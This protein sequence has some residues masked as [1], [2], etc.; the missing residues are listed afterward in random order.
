MAQP[1][2][3]TAFSGGEW[4][5]DL[6]SRVDLAKYHSAAQ[7]LKNFVVDYR[8]GAA[9]RPGTRYILQARDSTNQVRLIPFQASFTVSY[10]LEFG[11][12]YIRFFS[13][14]TAV[15]ETAIVI[16]GV[17]NAN[18]AV[19]TAPG[20]NYVVN[21][22]VFVNNV[23]G[24]SQLNGNYYI[25]IAVTANTF[26]I[27]GLNGTPVDS[28]AFGV[29]AGGGTTA[30]VYTIT[31][32]YSG[33]ELALVKFAQNVQSMV[34]CHPNHSAQLLTL[35]AANNW[36]LTTIAYGATVLPPTA[37]AVT[38]T[39]VGTGVNYS[40]TVTSVDSGGQE[41][42]KSIPGFLDNKADIRITPGTTT[43]NW[44]AADGAVS[45]NIYRAELNYGGVIPAG[46]AYGFLGNAT[47]LTFIDSNIA[48]DFSESPPISQD[49]FQGSSVLSLILE[50]NGAYT[51]V[52]LVTIDP[53]ASGEQ[54]TAFCSLTAVNIAQLN[55][56]PSNFD[57]ALNLGGGTPTGFNLT[58][59]NGVVCNIVSSSIAANTS[60]AQLYRINQLQVIAG[61]SV[62]SGPVPT[63]MAATGYSGPNL[64][65][66]NS[67]FT[68]DF[69]WVV[70]TNG[71]VLVSGG[72]GYLTAPGV[73]IN[74]GPATA[75]ATIQ[76]P[77]SGGGAPPSGIAGGNPEVPGFFQERLVLASQPNAL[78]TFYMSVPGAP[79]NFNIS[80]PVQ[81]SDSIT[82]QITSG[83]LNQIKS[84]APVPAG[85]IMFTNRASWLIN[86]GGGGANA[87]GV[88]V[89]P[90]NISANAQ[91]FNGASDVPP[92]IS[93]FDILYVQ[94]KGAVVRDLTFNFYAAIYTGTDVTVMAS[95]LFYGFTLDEWAWAEEPFKIVWAIRSDGTLLSLTFMKEQEMQGW[96]HSDTQGL[97]RSIC[98]VTEQV[99]FGAVDAIYTVVQRAVGGQWLQYI[100][101]MVERIFP[102]GME[103]AWCVDAALQT[104]P[105]NAGN[106]AG[107]PS[108]NVTAT[109]SAAFGPSNV[110]FS[111]N[112]GLAANV[113]GTTLRLGG[114]IGQIT[115]VASGS[116]CTVNFTTA[117][118]QVIPYT[119][120]PVPQTFDWSIWFPT[121]KVLGLQH[122]A[123]LQVSGVAD[124]AVVG[125]L[126]VQPDGSVNLPAPATKITLGLL[127]QPQLQTLRLDLGEPTA[128]GKRKSIIG[129]TLRVKDTLGL[130]S[131]K[132]LQTLTV[133]KD[134][135]LGQ[136]NIQDNRPVT[137]LYTG[138][139]R[140]I[141]DPQWDTFGTYYIVQPNPL[142]VTILGLMPE[143]VVGDTK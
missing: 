8:G 9:S 130:S 86:G 101:R 76:L 93:N 119:T 21:D 107:I 16:T 35:V 30:R 104:Q 24:T 142:P 49:P 29:Y 79:F 69:N 71:L 125:P 114:G 36:T 48:P 134:L 96:A 118:T 124:G 78:Q 117:I 109:A 57:I 91:S 39:M 133:M 1:V 129:L 11:A 38:T 87:A 98:T 106:I 103:D 132:S 40:Y 131:G 72:F 42:D 92:I 74:P 47:G 59:S 120:M 102:Y 61:G 13:N 111:V 84:M 110:T 85:L 128:Q 37:V 67:D 41:S 97:F 32:P 62:T 88:P 60:N 17:T 3:Q 7:L 66:L 123:G 99:S 135:Q 64:F 2:I 27:S 26:T 22:W 14:G 19:I 33:P 46:S 25:V 112:I 138:D 50:T 63:N 137:N 10:V 127:Y 5:P 115:G 141:L 45:Y 139:A 23:G 51:A 136:L 53:P 12:N 58:F 28:T 31:S 83:V 15:V 89:T 52:P 100:E 44:T 82:A 68:A 140:V 81:P 70:A 65:S 75:I 43:V 105:T 54:A 73:H 121:A 126:T 122:L 116:S 6:Y 113:I 95:H 80:D 94:S 55:H 77:P 56:A 4:S 108:N 143:V 34:I 18:P 20:H 90:T